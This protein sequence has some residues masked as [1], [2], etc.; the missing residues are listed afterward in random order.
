MPHLFTGIMFALD[1]VFRKT[2]PLFS[3]H[4]GFLA[5][6]NYQINITKYFVTHIKAHNSQA[7]R[8]NNKFVLLD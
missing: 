2:Q 5:Y 6:V 7:V 8:A 4:N 1:S 3:S